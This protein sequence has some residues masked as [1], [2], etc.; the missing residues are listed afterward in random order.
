MRRSALYPRIPSSPGRVTQ[1]PLAPA[2]PQEGRDSRRRRRTE[3]PRR[4][5][6]TPRTPASRRPPC[7]WRSTRPCSPS[8][9]GSDERRSRPQWRTP[10]LPGRT[11]TWSRTGG[12]WT[13]RT[14]RSG[15]SCPR[16]V[17]WRRAGAWLTSPPG[18]PTRAELRRRRRRWTP[19]TRPSP[20]RRSRSR[21]SWLSPS[22]EVGQEQPV[23]EAGRGVRRPGVAGHG[24]PLPAD[25]AR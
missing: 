13:G 9:T 12:R 21:I 18:R 11:Q 10:G 24:L 7:R 23:S 8:W 16:A 3:V 20:E 15:T 19:S 6:S 1:P 14:A 17:P 25:E 5:Q 2:A 22:T 4:S